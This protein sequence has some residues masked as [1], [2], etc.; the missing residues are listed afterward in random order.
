MASDATM[1]G[2]RRRGPFPQHLAWHLD[3]EVIDKGLWVGVSQSEDERGSEW[4][5]FSLGLVSLS[6]LLLNIDPPPLPIT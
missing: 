1:V 2:F 4:S 3:V 5:N 6:F